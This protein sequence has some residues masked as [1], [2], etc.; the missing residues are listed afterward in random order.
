MRSSFFGGP[1]SF[2]VSF[3]SVLLYLSCQSSEGKIESENFS[4]NI[5]LTTSVCWWLW[6]KMKVAAR[7]YFESDV[8]FVQPLVCLWR[9]KSRRVG[10]QS[11]SGAPVLVWLFRRLT[12]AFR[13]LVARVENLRHAESCFSAQ[14]CAS[15]GIHQ[16]NFH[17]KWQKVWSSGGTRVHLQVCSVSNV[18]AVK[19]IKTGAF[20]WKGLWHFDV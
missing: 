7:F 1:R 8:L 20:L 14:L 9:Q 15:Q 6:W 2:V 11:P 4:H 10:N 3:S 18:T 19:S 13:N 5:A 17:L 12:A 16:G